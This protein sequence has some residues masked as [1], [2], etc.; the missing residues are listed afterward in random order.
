MKIM[1]PAGRTCACTGTG[2][3]IC[4]CAAI[5]AVGLLAACG[6]KGPLQLP[7]HGKD[8]PWPVRTGTPAPGPDSPPNPASQDPGSDAERHEYNHAP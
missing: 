3:R 6:Q 5:L 8:T 2:A 4:A 7:G 1:P